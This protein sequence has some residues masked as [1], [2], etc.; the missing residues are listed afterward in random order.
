MNLYNQLL[1]AERPASRPALLLPDGRTVSYGMLAESAARFA[2]VIAALGVRVGDRVA[3]Q[4]EKS[5][6]ALALYLACLRGGFIFIP[7]NTAYREHETGYILGDADPALL[8][9]VPE[10]AEEARRLARP[11]TQILTLDQSGG[12]SLMAQAT[13]V[14]T[15]D[16][17]ATLAEDDLAVL[18]YTSGTTGR[19]KGAMQSHRTLSVNARALADCWQYSAEDVLLHCLPLF[20]AHGLQVSSHCALLTGSTMVWLAGFDLDQ[21]LAWLPRSTVFMG[22]P[23]HYARLLASDRLV[24]ELCRSVRLFISGSA[25]LSV[26]TH[27]QFEQGTG[28]RIVERYGMTETGINASNPVTGERKAGS[29]GR[30]LVGAEIRVVGADGHVLPT[31][32]EGEI[33]IRGPSLCSGYWR[34]REATALAFSA[35]GWFSTGDVGRFDDDGYLS[36]ISRVKDIIITGG[37][38][39]YPTEVESVL[40]EIGGVR[41]AAVIGVPHPDFGEGVIGLLVLDAGDEIDERR[42]L[43]ELKTVLANYK[44]PKRLII[45]PELPRNAMGK[46]LKPQLRA[47]YRDLLSG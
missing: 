38:N 18:L 19:P 35:D 14:A 36:L 46:V 1:P 25:P 21:V 40:E 30:P 28:H 37:Y 11:G 6:E 45:V 26:D 42:T 16:P 7:L 20:H 2:T 12:G 23:T 22:V 13:A 9:V 10:R 39:V 15:I 33:Q 43:A 4:V 32:R 44:V 27:R 5:P 24:P 29:V 31:G 34:N 8:V 41:E 17:P 47:E 3:V